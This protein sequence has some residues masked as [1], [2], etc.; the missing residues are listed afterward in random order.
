[1]SGWHTRSTDC[2]DTDDLSAEGVAQNRGYALVVDRLYG[3]ND[4]YN[5]G[6]QACRGQDPGQNFVLAEFPNT[7]EIR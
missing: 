4:V 1:L 6:G 7:G 3:H 5:S 2:E